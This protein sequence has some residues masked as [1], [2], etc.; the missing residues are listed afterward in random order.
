MAT[1][2]R[3][4]LLALPAIGVIALIVWMLRPAPSMGDDPDVFKTVDA[5]YTAVRERKLDRVELCEQRLQDFESAGKLPT[6]AA[7]RLK[8]IVQQCK[9]G[10]WESA[11]K[12]LY[13][14][15]MDQQRK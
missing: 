14:F 15:M 11:T 13:E 9:D 1:I 6:D 2:N 7:K 5:L 12:R 8:S 10:S 4:W 3:R